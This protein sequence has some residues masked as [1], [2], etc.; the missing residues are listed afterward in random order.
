MHFDKKQREA[1]LAVVETVKTMVSED[2]F[3]AISGWLNDTENGYIYEYHIVD[4]PQGEYQDEGGSY[5]EV[6][7]GMWVD[8]Y[9][10]FTGDDYHGSIAIKINE[11]SYLQVSFSM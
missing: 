5:W 6:L 2:Y 10:G 7:G 11:N 1:D 8:Q 3:S 4:E 9:A